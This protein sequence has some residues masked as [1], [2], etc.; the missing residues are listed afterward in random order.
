[1]ISTTE[2]AQVY[3]T[4]LSIPGMN[5]TVKISLQISRKNVLLLDRIIERGLSTNSED[6]KSN[7]LTVV[8]PEVLHE[9]TMLSEECLKKAGLKDLSEKLKT[10]NKT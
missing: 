6:K 7:I 4:I 8:P 1:M 3:D 10:F 9:L 2:M 5:E